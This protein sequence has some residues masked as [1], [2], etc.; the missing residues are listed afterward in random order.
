M[1]ADIKLFLSVCCKKC[2]VELSTSPVDKKTNTNRILTG[3]DLTMDCVK[4]VSELE[5]VYAKKGT[6]KSLTKAGLSQNF[7]WLGPAQVAL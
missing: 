2:S 4:S 1:Y 7:S 3:S 5:P 6:G